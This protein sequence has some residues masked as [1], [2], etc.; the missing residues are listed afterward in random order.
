MRAVA[1]A[2]DCLGQSLLAAYLHGSAVAGGLRPHSDIDILV[3]IDRPTTR[4]VREKLLAELMR[5]SGRPGSAA[6]PRPLE[7]IVFNRADLDPP[8]YPAR[9]EFVFGEWL[10]AAFEAGRVPEPES[11]PEFTILIAAAR[12]N[13][14]PLAGP[15][16]ADLLPPVADRDM[17]RAIG[18]CLGP[19]LDTLEGDERNVLLTLARM[20]R[21]LATGEIVPKG[22]AAAWAASRLDGEAA[23]LVAHAAD[24]YLGRAGDDWR[25]RREASRRVAGM[26]RDRLVTML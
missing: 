25:A 13:A 11:D 22:E 2:R 12:G 14:R 5:I 1:V 6:A 21:T 3:V 9:A 26:L 10:R 16:A 20:W 4:G 19:L 7:L 23:E 18:D 8:S 17:R 24:A 15:D